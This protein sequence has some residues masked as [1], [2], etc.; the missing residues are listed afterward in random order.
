MYLHGA[1]SAGLLSRMAG[2]YLPG[3]ECLLHEIRLKFLKPILT[4]CELNIE[5]VVHWDDGENGEVAISIRNTDGGYLM[6]EGGYRFG[7]HQRLK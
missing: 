5:G 2:M 6:V 1:F 7:R 3:T 4:P